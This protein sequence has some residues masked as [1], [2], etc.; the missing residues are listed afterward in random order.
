MEGPPDAQRAALLEETAALVAYYTDGSAAL[1][2]DLYDDERQRAGARGRFIA[3]PVVVDRA[4]K[5]R[6]AVVWATEPLFTPTDETVADRLAPVIQ[7]ETARPY[8]DTITANRRRDPAAVGWRR[9]AAGGCKFCQMLAGRGVVYKEATARFASHPNCHC[10]A[11]PVFDGNDGEEATALQY[12]ASQRRRTPAQ[13]ER[14]RAY[15]NEHF[16]DAPG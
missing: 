12:V 1:A 15:L 7:L 13:Q 8:R 3:E 16:P 6:R 10:T 9:I 4:E 5:L 14:L 11:A 2:A